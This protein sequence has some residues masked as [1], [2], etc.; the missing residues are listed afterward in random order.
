V[1][2][3]GYYF[4]PLDNSYQPP[5]ELLSFL[6]EGESP[7]CITFGSMVNRN[8]E[9]IDRIVSESLKQ[10]GNRGIILS[11]W[12]GIEKVSSNDLLYLEAVPH[13][14]LLPHCKLVIH[15][16]GAGTTA[17]GLHAGIPN[18]VVPFLGDQ[19]FWGE[20]V[21]ALGA[22][23]K[24]ILVKSFSVEKLTQAIARAESETICKRAQILSQQ[25]TS[26]DGT[27]ESAEWIEKYSNNFHM[28]G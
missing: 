13:D 4:V 19:L 25:I 26:E 22:G 9:R 16:G 8:Q 5:A 14:W 23:P 12:S 24:P 21:H 7:L 11:G 28:Q 6:Q 27:G 18:I 2:V 3:T 10:T 15:H 1:H 20:R 17:T